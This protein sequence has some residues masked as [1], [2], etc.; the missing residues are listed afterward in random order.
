MNLLSGFEQRMWITCKV[1]YIWLVTRVSVQWGTNFWPIFLYSKTQKGW[2]YAILDQSGSWA[3]K[4]MNM[5]HMLS[6]E[7]ILQVL[8]GAK[9]PFDQSTL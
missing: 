3:N 7:L 6:F 4:L 8:F 2:V 1:A 9:G 5:T